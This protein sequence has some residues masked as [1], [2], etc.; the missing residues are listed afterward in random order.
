MVEIVEHHQGMVNKFLGDGLMALF[1][2]QQAGPPHA[3]AALNAAREM[4]S[5][6]REINHAVGSIGPLKL[7]I[8][9]GLHTGPAVVGC[10]GSEH[11]MEFTAIGDTVNVA[12]R[13]ESLTKVVGH[14]I[15]LTD[16]TRRLV[17]DG[18]SLL[19]LPPQIIKGKDQPLLVYT[20]E[21]TP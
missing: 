18:W 3:S 15:L 4:V 8:G 7:E 13:V 17:G 14:P 1:G 16:A 9:I 19:A 12:A 10:I 20:L 6:T 5:R 21:E 11:R 2:T